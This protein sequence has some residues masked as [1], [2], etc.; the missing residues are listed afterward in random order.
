MKKLIGLLALS[1]LSLNAFAGDIAFTNAH[2]RIVNVDL[3]CPGGDE[4]P[5]CDATG[6]KVTVETVIG[7]LD[8]LMFSHFEMANNTEVPTL[9]A[10]S[11][12]RADSDS[13]RV[14]CIVRP[15]RKTITVQELTDTQLEI[16]NEEI[17]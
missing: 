5:S 12:V 11:V 10:V 7:C 16:I 9:R 13:A 17:R 8:K 1:L 2:F 3:F 15:I 14:R 4:G 6:G